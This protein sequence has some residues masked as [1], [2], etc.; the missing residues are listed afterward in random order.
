MD[1]IG[2]SPFIV[3]PTIVNSMNSDLANFII[4]L[5]NSGGGLIL[6]DM[7]SEYRDVFPLGAIID[8][9]KKDSIR[10]E[11][12]EILR[13]I[14]YFESFRFIS[15]IDELVQIDFVPVKAARENNFIDGRYITRIRVCPQ[16]STLVFYKENK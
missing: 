14:M 3:I 5:L 2:Q 13:K 15:G 12:T 10:A 4:A 9:E 16:D 6:F 8:E 1:E 11:F 7:K